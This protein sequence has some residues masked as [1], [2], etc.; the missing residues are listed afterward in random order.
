MAM[1]ELHDIIEQLL[2]ERAQYDREGKV[3]LV[4]EVDAELK[5]LGAAGQAP[6][7]RAVRLVR[8]AGT[9]L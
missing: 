8:T 1:P 9:R 7:E 4:R 5:V 3:D 6:R 2:R